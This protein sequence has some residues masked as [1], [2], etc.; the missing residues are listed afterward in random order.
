MRQRTVA[1]HVACFE[2]PDTQ[3]REQ[4][5]TRRVSGHRLNARRHAPA[6]R[7]PAQCVLA[8]HSPYRIKPTHAGLI[9]PDLAH[10]GLI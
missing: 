7:C 3:P 2:R 8:G 9:W 4:G 1:C 10:A 5:P 6:P